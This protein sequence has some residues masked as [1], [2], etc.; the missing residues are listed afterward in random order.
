ME[1]EFDNE[2]NNEEIKDAAGEAESTVFE[3][4]EETAETAQAPEACSDGESETV[5]QPLNEESGDENPVDEEAEKY[6]D[7][8]S[9]EEEQADIICPN[10]GREEVASGHEYCRK[11][12]KRLVKVKV[13]FFSYLAGAAAILV[14]LFAFIIA[15]LSA[16]P[17]LQVFEGLIYESGSLVYPALDSYR[18]TEDVIKTVKSRTGAFPFLGNFIAKGS[19]LDNK[20]FKNTVK[21]YNPL[22][23]RQYEE[24]IF[25]SPG[26][27][28]FREK[29]EA[30]RENRKVYSAY[31]NMYTKIMNTY[32]G[33]AESENVTPEDGRKAILSV[34]SYRGKDGVDSVLVDLFE[35]DIAGMS[36]MGE[37]E[38]YKYLKMAVEDQK[39]S[40]IDWR[41]L[42]IKQYIEMLLRKG[43]EK[44]A[45][46]MLESLAEEDKSA[47][48]PYSLLAKVYHS[49][50]ETDKLEDI[51]YEYCANNVTADGKQ[52][53]SA[54]EL[55][56]YLY[57]V[58]GKYEDM[59]ETAESAM[60]LYDLIP[61]YNRQ[62]ALAYLSQG[63][64]DE[65]FEQAITADDK[66]YYRSSY[67]GD[68]EAMNEALF[69]TLYV[70]AYLCDKYG[71]KDTENADKIPEILKSFEGRTFS[72]DKVE[73]ILS[74]KAEVKDILKEGGS[75]LI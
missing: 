28:V 52:A 51:V 65:A 24:Y 42:Y 72:G 37:E 46:K 75:D 6:A 12:E 64:Y 61:E 69:A 31:E 18:G 48:A 14:S 40:D 8:E 32:N 45:L 62:L 35:Y 29:S 58:T 39:K 38:E 55:L 19:N 27:S 21:F 68:S 63:K 30:V 25:T 67:Y 23:A 41:F 59:E 56:L 9:E 22:K 11:C 1:K 73:R 10:C 71:E 33:I 3:A 50:G 49:N 53:D 43:G 20:I 44:E 70:S 34:E 60:A 54:Y 5:G 7:S 15:M 4:G 17:A 74:G 16:L 26:A 47:L 57:R 2:L 36:G 13:P 66:A